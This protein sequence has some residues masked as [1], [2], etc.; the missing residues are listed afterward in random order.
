[1]TTPKSHRETPWLTRT[2]TP[3]EDLLRHVFEPVLIVTTLMTIAALSVGVA[4]AASPPDLAGTIGLQ[5]QSASTPYTVVQS[6]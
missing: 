1:M 3:R 2:R 5:Q 6:R 4:L